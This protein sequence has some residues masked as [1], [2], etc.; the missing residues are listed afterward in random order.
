MIQEA[1]RSDSGITFQY[2]EYNLAKEY[3]PRHDGKWNVISPC[4][5]VWKNERCFMVG[6]S[7]ERERVIV[8][9]VD[10]MGLP[11]PT[12]QPRAPAP[13]DYDVRNYTGRV[14]N[15]YDE[16]PMETVTLRCRR[17]MIGHIIDYFG[18]NVEPFHVTEETFDVQVSIC[19]SAT[20]F[21]WVLGFGD[22]MTIAVPAPVCAR[23]Q[24]TLRR[25]AER[26]GLG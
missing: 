19:V 23:Y 10:R 5:T 4:A 22:D 24:D 6:W 7:D 25:A 15:M 12:G 17:H 13:A 18:K 2:Y 8:F 9:R 14:F 26:T 11:K 1:I 16:G 20:F 21:A 3:V